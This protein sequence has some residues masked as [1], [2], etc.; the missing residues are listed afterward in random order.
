MGILFFLRLQYMALNFWTQTNFR[1]SKI[2]YLIFLELQK[3]S[4]QFGALFFRLHTVCPTS[5]IFLFTPC[6]FI[7]CSFKDSN[8]AL[9]CAIISSTAECDWRRRSFRRI[10]ESAILTLVS[11]G[12]NLENSNVVRVEKINFRIKKSILKPFLSLKIEILFN[13]RLKN[14][15]FG[16]RIG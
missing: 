13:F 4:H 12:R 16:A 15:F 10:S 7:C 2:E 1:V 14:Q 3:L 5:N 11:F 6:K 9:P 8:T